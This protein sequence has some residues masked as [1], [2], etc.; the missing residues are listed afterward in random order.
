MHYIFYYC[1]FLHFLIS[2]SEFTLDESRQKR[3]RD[4]VDS[5]RKKASLDVL[6]LIITNNETTIFEEIFSDD[7]DGTVTKDS[8]F[9]IGSI[10][11]TFTALSFLKLPNSEQL[12]NKTLDQFETLGEYLD[13]ESLKNITVGELLNH[14]SGLDSFDAKSIGTKGTHSYSNY[15]FALL[16]KII[17]EIS[18]QSYSEYITEKIFKP[19]EMTNSK[20]EYN[21]KVIDSYDTFLGALRKYRNLESKYKE[22]DGFFIPVGYISSTI[23]DMGIYMRS[24]LNGENTEYL[25]KM[26]VESTEIS[27]HFYYG[28]GMYITKRSDF[29]MYHH[30]GAANNFLSDFYLIPKLSLGIF[31]T[32]NSND[33][34]VLQPTQQLMNAVKNFLLNDVVEQYDGVD[35]SLYLVTHFFIDFMVIIIL[36]LPVTYLVITIVRRIKKRKYT[37]FNGIKGMI[38]F[39]VD[40]LILL[41]APIIILIVCFGVDGSRRANYTTPNDIYFTIVAF[42]VTLFL[43]FIIKIVYFFLYNKLGWEE[44]TNIYIED[45]VNDLI[46]KDA[47]I[48]LE[49]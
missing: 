31:L 20:A 22:K 35:H 25:T 11:K 16:G 29:T 17:E 14:T 12:I 3:L 5:L 18:K 10:T 8:A 41:I 27:D 44:K 45:N 4:L 13:E 30:N 24:Y 28:L 6:G 47:N 36:A 9:V 7:N 34:L 26:G 21:D 49:G 38:F 43:N 23:N 32:T 46:T 33:V 40:V 2:K 48:E 42:C 1:L 37:W 19:L 39:G 15:G